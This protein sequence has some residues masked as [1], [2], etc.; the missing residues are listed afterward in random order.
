ML[1]LP[2][3]LPRNV[4]Q[5]SADVDEELLLIQQEAQLKLE[6]KPPGSLGKT[7]L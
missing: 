1:F 7:K 2:D 6:V 4:P 5:L 3:L